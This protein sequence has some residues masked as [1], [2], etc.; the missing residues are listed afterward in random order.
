MAT[1]PKLAVV[2]NSD[3]LGAPVVEHIYTDMPDAVDVHVDI[4]HAERLD[5]AIEEPEM[6]VAMLNMIASAQSNLV[7]IY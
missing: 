2:I 6:A 5:K 3:A 4:I 1:K 7:E